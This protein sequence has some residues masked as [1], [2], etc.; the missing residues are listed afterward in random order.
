MGLGY[1]A[2]YP[3]ALQGIDVVVSVCFPAHVEW[4]EDSKSSVPNTTWM[5]CPSKVISM[6]IVV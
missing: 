4:M 6:S 5:V 2:L 1:V 3:H